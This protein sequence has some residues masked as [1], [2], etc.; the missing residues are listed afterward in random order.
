MREGEIDLHVFGMVAG[1]RTDET[2]LDLDGTGYWIPAFARGSMMYW[3]FF[4]CFEYVEGWFQGS[5]CCVCEGG[6]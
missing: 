4:E 3:E 5:A 2:G 6:G 1:A